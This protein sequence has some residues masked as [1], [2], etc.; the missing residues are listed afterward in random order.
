M[1]DVSLD[2]VRQVLDNHLTISMGVESG[3][4]VLNNVSNS[5]SSEQNANLNKVVLTLVNLEYE[6]NRQF[7]GG[8]RYNG[9]QVVQVNPA[10]FFNMDVLVSV[11]FTTYYESLKF[12]TAVIAFFQENMAFNRHTHPAM[13]DGLSV[14]K[15]EIENSPSEKTHNLWTALGVSYLPS[16]VYK[17]RHVSVQSG[18]VKG[19]SAPVQDVA[20]AARP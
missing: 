2:F 12:L 18:Q 19:A 15:F 10:L 13:P 11:N 14:L 16:I 6:T 1:I 5:G 8:Q 4:V 20:V 17:I 7:Y 3:T 9:Q